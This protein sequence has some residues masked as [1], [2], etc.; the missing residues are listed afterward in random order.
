MIVKLVYSGFLMALC[1]CIHAA[2][3][4][5]ALRSLR[6]LRH[7]TFGFWS[8]AFLFVTLAAWIVWLH[9][10]EIAAWGLFLAWQGV[11]PDVSTAFYFSTATYT[12]TGYGDVVLPEGWRLLASVE[13]LT[14]I[15]MCGWSTAFFFAVI[16]QLTNA[17]N[18]APT[19]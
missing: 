7:R 12:T 4:T 18:E 8:G 6:T 19:A 9:L 10:L 14:G 15:L 1:V 13:S 3:I 17:R 16:S 5:A 11:L 2:G